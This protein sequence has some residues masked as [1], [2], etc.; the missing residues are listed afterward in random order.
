MNIKTIQPKQPVSN[1]QY[2][3]GSLPTDFNRV[4]RAS[5]N[6]RWGASLN[7][8]REQAITSAMNLL[9]DLKTGAAPYYLLNEALQPRTKHTAQLISEKYPGI[10]REEMT[11]SD[12]PLLL[13]DV[14]D[15][16][17]LNR[18]AVKSFDFETHVLW[19]NRP[20]RDF[21]TVRRIASDG[22]ENQYTLTPEGTEVNFT[23][24]SETGY[25]YTPAVY[26]N[27]VQVS[28][29]AL[30]TDDLG[31]FALVPERLGRG[32]RRTLEQFATELYTDASGPDATYFSVGN[33]N[34]LTAALDITALG[35]A[36]QT[37]TGFTDS[38]GDPIMVDGVVLV[39][40]PALWVTAQNILNQ[41]TVDVVA[42][43]GDSNQTV[44]VNNWM[45]RNMTLV[46]NPYIPLVATSA[47]G[48]TS[49]FLF[50]NP[51]TGRQGFEMN[52]V[53]G[54]STPQLFQKMSNTMRVGG[55]VDQMM[56]SFSTMTQEY[57]GVLAFGGTTM[58][59]NAA[60]GS[61]GTT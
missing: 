5:S 56:G 40:P 4:S 30:L 42:V 22:A 20:L 17:M 11:I 26:T 3:N 39:V 46:M 57:K 59:T 43:G 12:F 24:M 45:V 54:F 16:M 21:R 44:R 27:G 19:N 37:L 48:N 18:Y 55:G 31:A 35:S 29:Q 60:V 7:P 25:T 32:G 47:N 9:A 8:V 34:L 61:N 38:G 10:L 1:S 15:R 36:I 28:Y 2:T 58:D 13:G 41:L 50:S 51:N 33:G 14:L 23:S 53:Q 52:P 49:W 6:P